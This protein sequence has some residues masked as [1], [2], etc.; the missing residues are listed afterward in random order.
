MKLLKLYPILLLSLTINLPACSEETA[1]EIKTEIPVTPDEPDIPPSGELLMPCDA[2]ATEQTQR[3]YTY[4]RSVYGE[5]CLSATMAN[6]NW[7]TTEAGHVYRLTGKYP[8]INCF[9]FIH[10]HYSPA[11]WIDYT[12]LTPVKE[13][14]EA[15]GIVSLMWH[16]MVPATEDS[17]NYTCSPTETAF[18]CSNVFKENSWESKFF[19]AQL[20]KVCAT[21][22]KLQEAGI[23]ALWRPLHEGAGN[24]PS[25]GTAWF[26]WGD[27]GADSYVRLWKLMYS[28]MQQ[29]GIHNLIWIWTAQNNGDEDWYPGNDCVDIIGRDLYGRG[30]TDSYN[31]WT[32]VSDLYAEKMVALSECGNL[33]DGRTVSARQASI[34]EQWSSKGVRWLYFMPW[35]DYDFNTG[36]ATTNVMCDDD[37]WTVAMTRNYVLIREDVKHLSLTSK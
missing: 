37:F 17:G 32:T 3:I 2:Q 18:R 20:D 9:D 29:K 22:L 28:Y 35:Y 24:A 23:S 33:L 26:W 12:D 27:D 14:A 1:E 31:E 5:K 36:A 30:A 34:G 7:N 25:G 19:Y 15:G 6:V 10:I 16:F 21:L 4:L 8:A 11:D 13:W